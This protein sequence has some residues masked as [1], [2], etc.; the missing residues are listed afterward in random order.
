M[1]S[2]DLHYTVHSALP[3][4]EIVERIQHRAMAHGFRTLHV[5][6]VQATL[7]EKGFPLPSYSIIEVC[8]AK[9]AHRILTRHPVVGM[10]LPC[11]IAVYE[12]EQGCDI[13]MMKPQLMSV[14]MPDLD[15]DSIPEE[16]EVALVQAI[17]EAIA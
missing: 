10:M 7:A 8:N 5:H 4:S 6:D 9:F 11:R 12:R 1:T 16:V 13:T 2:S 17:E 15:L 14:M 3:F